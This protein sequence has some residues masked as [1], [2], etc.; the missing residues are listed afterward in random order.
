MKARDAWH[1]FGKPVSHQNKE[2]PPVSWRG[3]FVR[4]PELSGHHHA[5][6]AGAAG[7]ATATARGARRD[8]CHARQRHCCC[9]QKQIFHDFLLLRFRASSAARTRTQGAHVPRAEPES[10]RENHVRGG[11]IGGLS[12]RAEAVVSDVE[13]ARPV[14]PGVKKPSDVGQKRI[15]VEHE[16]VQQLRGCDSWSAHRFCGDVCSCIILHP[17][18]LEQ[19]SDGFG[20]AITFDLPTKGQRKVARHTINNALTPALRMTT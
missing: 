16:T 19:K 14:K 5:A 2:A 20:I 9:N 11:G 13:N 7:A 10:L 15:S 8:R 4:L 17:D 1:A 12:I 6:S 3:P 18:I